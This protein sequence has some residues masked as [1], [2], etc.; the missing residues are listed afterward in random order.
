MIPVPRVSVRNSDRYPNNPRAGILE[1]AALAP[2]DL[3][4]EA[5]VPNDTI[6]Y[7]SWNWNVDRMYTELDKMVNAFQGE[8]AFEKLVAENVNKNLELNLREDLLAALSGRVTFATWYE[9]PVKF[10]SQTT[11]IA[12]ELKDPEKFKQSFDKLM[13]KII[14]ETS[15]EQDPNEKSFDPRS[16]YRGVKCWKFEELTDEGRSRRRAGESGEE[17]VEPEDEDSRLRRESVRQAYP[18]I[19]VTDTHIIASDSRAFIEKAIDTMKDGS[20]P[21]KDDEQFNKVSRHMKRLL[22]TSVPGGVL[23]SRPE[24]SL[25]ML[26]DMA[27]SESAKHFLARGAEENEIVGSFKKVLDENPLPDFDELR[28][29]FAPTGMYVTSDETGV[30]ILGFQLKPND[31]R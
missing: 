10:N 12:V 18:N 24:R 17:P 23:F 7:I 28:Q 27:K 11:A 21:L 20:A 30:H 14:K 26:F 9:K 6:S 3:T 4:P 2:G 13:A 22:G 25:E 19:A 15:G 5:W 1:M 8:G 16:D 31:D 29:S